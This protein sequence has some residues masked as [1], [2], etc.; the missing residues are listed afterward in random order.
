MASPIKDELKSTSTNADTRA[1][2]LTFDDSI[3]N[4]TGTDET[5]FEEFDEEQASSKEKETEFDNLVARYFRDVRQFSL[6]KREQER[7]LWREIERAQIQVRRALWLSP[8]ALPTLTR[9]WQQVELEEIPLHRVLRDLPEEQADREALR[10]RFGEAVVQLQELSVQLRKLRTRRRMSVKS[11][12]KRRSL[13]QQRAGLWQKWLGLCETLSLHPNIHEDMR[14]ALEAAWQ[15]TPDNRG[16][17]AAWTRFNRVNA[18][19]TQAKAQMMR[20]NLRLVIHVANR[21]RG[22]GVPFLDLIQEGNIGLMRALDKFEHSR[23]LKFVTYAHWWVRQAISR[24]IT[25]QYRTVRLPN[26]VVER[27]NKL[28]AVGDRLWDLHGRAPNAQEISVELGWSTKEVEDLMLAVQ[29]VMRLHQ[30][31]SDDGSMLSDILEDEQAP[32]ADEMLADEQLQHRLADCLASLTDREAFIVRLRYGL[33]SDH[34]HTLQ[35]IADILG[36]SRERVRQL[37]RQAFEKL[38]QPHRSALLADFVTA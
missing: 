10:A 2:R 29:P 17:R 12:N 26:H 35:E 18:L 38:R 4:E 13:R 34:P 16:L 22:R 27:K 21:Y 15:A 32:K 36:L 9:L 23:G 11:A 5:S 31:V 3:W 14:L 6:L 30:P 8:I 1:M 28:R 24:A 19:L 25:E 37:E 7:E 20:A 33:E